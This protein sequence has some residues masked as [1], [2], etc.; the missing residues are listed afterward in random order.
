M[1]PITYFFIKSIILCNKAHRDGAL[2]TTRGNLYVIFLNSAFSLDIP[3]LVF[4]YN[5]LEE[6]S[7]QYLD[8]G[9]GYFFLCYRQIMKNTVYILA[10]KI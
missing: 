8:L 4:F 1:V 7:S 3:F 5:I 9:A 2:K 6:S 10:I